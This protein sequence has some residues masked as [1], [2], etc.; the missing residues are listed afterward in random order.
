[1]KVLSCA[2][3]AK[4]VEIMSKGPILT[5]MSNCAV[6]LPSI[7]AFDY[8]PYFVDR[9]L[10]AVD[11]NMKVYYLFFMFSRCYMLYLDF[12]CTGFILVSILVLVLFNDLVSPELASLSM[13]Y[14]TALLAGI[15]LLGW[16]T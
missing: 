14:T 6:G 15:A 1:V 12:V 9:M 16:T 4:R 7:R 10:S 13:S 3:E 2:G 11:E 5:M 8:I